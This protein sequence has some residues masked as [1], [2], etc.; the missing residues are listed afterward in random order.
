MKYIHKGCEKCNPIFMYMVFVICVSYIV[1][2]ISR[3]F[4]QFLSDDIKNKG[5]SL[6]SKMLIIFMEI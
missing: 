4:K 3:F 5:Y 2:L 1:I 6:F